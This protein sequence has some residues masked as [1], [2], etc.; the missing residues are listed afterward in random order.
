MIEV[1]DEVQRRGGRPD[2][3]AAAGDEDAH[4]SP[5]ET[6]FAPESIR[7]VLVTG[8]VGALFHPIS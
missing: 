2:E 3:A 8:G 7:P 6:E 1:V 4:Q 5:F